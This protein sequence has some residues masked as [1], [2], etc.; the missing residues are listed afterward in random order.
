[1]S[2]ILKGLYDYSEA[3]KESKLVKIVMDWYDKL[4]KKNYTWANASSIINRAK[5]MYNL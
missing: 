2:R 3:Q 4:Y 1:M 5:K